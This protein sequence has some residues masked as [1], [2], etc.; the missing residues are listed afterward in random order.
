MA[1]IA[2]N[3][4]HREKISSLFLLLFFTSTFTTS[5]QNYLS[6]TL[7]K[8]STNSTEILYD[9]TQATIA[10]N[11]YHCTYKIL[12]SKSQQI[13][14]I[15]LVHD[16]SKNFVSA[17]VRYPNKNP[18]ILNITYKPTEC[19]LI[20]CDRNNLDTLFSLKKSYQLLISFADTG[21]DFPALH[22]IMATD[23]DELVLDPLTKFRVAK[24][25]ETIRV[26]IK[27]NPALYAR[28]QALQP[29]APDDTSP[30]KG[31]LMGVRDS[32]D[33]KRKT[34]IASAEN[35]KKSLIEDSIRLYKAKSVSEDGSFYKGDKKHGKPDGEGFLVSMKSIYKGIF[36]AG[37]F[38]SGS[39]L[40][41][42]NDYE[43]CGE[44][45]K[46]NF[47]GIGCLKFN[48]GIYYVG[49]FNAGKLMDGIMKWNESGGEFFYG[50]IKSFNRTGYGEYRT[51]SGDRYWGEFL[52]GR[53][54][55]GYISEAIG[56]NNSCWRFEN[57][58]K[59]AISVKS[60]EVV[61]SSIEL[62]SYTD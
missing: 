11:L 1:P 23:N 6:G 61:F 2:N 7:I 4:F 8:D 62:L 44:Y 24:H 51:K 13:L 5:A 49:T 16:K 39:A 3:K 41:R 38:I 15:K 36:R 52:N 47:S 19:G 14:T 31:I 28:F 9:R 46:S 12:N 17:T 40:I 20:L 37:V 32:V 56:T 27:K 33:I 18:R 43:Y 25:N 50:L 54:T 58:G 22:K 30:L 29:K 34:L 10:K 60:C 53:L 48:S 45:D 21:R 35:I 55:K 59:N 57:G 42:T 26:L